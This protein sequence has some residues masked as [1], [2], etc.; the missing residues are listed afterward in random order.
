MLISEY[1][2]VSIDYLLGNS[3]EFATSQ[4]SVEFKG[5]N[6]EYLKL[7]RE[8]QEGDFSPEDIRMIL[9]AVESANKSKK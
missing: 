1:F 7:A 6:L 3:N 8:L 9:K 5:I 2:K 4:L